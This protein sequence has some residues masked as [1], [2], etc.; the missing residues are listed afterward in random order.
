[1]SDM[2]FLRSEEEFDAVLDQPR[3][4]IYKHSP[5]CGLS[6]MAMTEV[7]FFMQDSPDVPIV[8]VDVIRD[9]PLS[10]RIA[11]RLGIQHESPQII[12]L[13]HGEPVWD[14][15]HRGVTAQALE[16]RTAA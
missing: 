1:M 5:L 13:E 7:R 2:R 9:R 16:E 4:L 12:L 8:A 15:S 14:T 11:E 3:A 6:D 10:R